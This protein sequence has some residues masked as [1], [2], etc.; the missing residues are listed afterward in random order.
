MTRYASTTDLAK[1][2]HPTISPEIVE[3]I[4]AIVTK[5]EAK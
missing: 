1:A 5:G 2:A 3:S 4:A